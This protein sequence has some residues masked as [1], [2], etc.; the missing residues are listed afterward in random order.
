MLGGAL[1]ECEASLWELLGTSRNLLDSSLG[2]FTLIWK[3]CTIHIN[4]KSFCYTCYLCGCVDLENISTRY[5]YFF[6]LVLTSPC[7]INII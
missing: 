4:V 6:V 7:H 1:R 5:M 2:M 3:I